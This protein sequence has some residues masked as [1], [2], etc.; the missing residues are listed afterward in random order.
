MSDIEVAFAFEI[1]GE[2]IDP[3]EIDDPEIASK[4]Q[5]VVES[6]SGKVG[7]LRCPQHSE[8]PRFICSGPDFDNLS[9]QVLG[10]CDRLVE[11]VKGLLQD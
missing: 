8:S 11:L 7:G 4:V 2:P 1:N 5:A 6:V 3:R 9:L 10:C